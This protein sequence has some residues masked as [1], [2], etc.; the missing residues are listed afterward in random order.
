MSRGRE[1]K[2]T[3]QVVM[4]LG[5]RDDITRVC[6]MTAYD[7]ARRGENDAETEMMSIDAGNYVAR[8]VENYVRV[9]DD[10]IFTFLPLTGYHRR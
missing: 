8:D 5:E 6:G 1:R 10:S 9:D 3:S 7:V 4:S 2:M